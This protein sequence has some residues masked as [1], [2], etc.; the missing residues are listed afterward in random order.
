MGQREIIKAQRNKFRETE[1]ALE[2]A[3]EPRSMGKVYTPTTEECDKHRRTH[4]PACTHPPQRSKQERG[5]PVLSLDYM[6]MGSGA[7]DEDKP[8]IAMHH[9]CGVQGRR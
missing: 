1:L 8:I 4:H 7:D 5:V 6:F 3:E 9:L 2:E